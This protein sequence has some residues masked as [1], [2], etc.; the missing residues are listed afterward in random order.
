MPNDSCACPVSGSKRVM[1]IDLVAEK[2]DA[3]R[4]FVRGRRI[5]LD[6]IAAHAEF[7]AREIHVVALVEHVDQPAEDGFAA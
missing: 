6:H 4:F 7:P 2:F 1:R 5:H 3:D